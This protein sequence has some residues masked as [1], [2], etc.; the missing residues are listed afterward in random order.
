MDL[1]FYVSVFSGREDVGFL[2]SQLLLCFVFS[3]QALK[4]ICVNALYNQKINCYLLQPSF[5]ACSLLLNFGS[6]REDGYLTH[7]GFIY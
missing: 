3:L 1:D 7:R 2:F 4:F 6:I 5:E